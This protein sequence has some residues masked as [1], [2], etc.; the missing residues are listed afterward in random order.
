AA[1]LGAESP[2]VMTGGVAKNAGVVKAL[3][4]KLSEQSAGGA[5]VA[6]TVP[7]DPRICGAFGAALIARDVARQ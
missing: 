1:R 3:G 6:L 5:R 4:E 2:Y 7:G